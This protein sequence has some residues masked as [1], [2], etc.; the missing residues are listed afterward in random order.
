MRTPMKINSFDI[1]EKRFSIRFRGFDIHEVD[2]F[3]E[4][5]S[6]GLKVLEAENSAMKEEVRRIKQLLKGY[7]NQEDVLKQALLNSQKVLDQMR[8]NARKSAENILAEAEVRAQKLLNRAHQRLSQL[9]EDIGE[10]KRQRIQIESQIRSVLETHAKL[11]D[12]AKT[13]TALLDAEENKIRFL[14]NAQ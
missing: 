6:T 12:A 9:H 1:Q 13:D 2:A 7:K 5:I 8:E 14:T 10:L 3:L 4:E 11:L